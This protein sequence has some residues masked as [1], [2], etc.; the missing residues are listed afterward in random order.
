MLS[1]AIILQNIIL[2][3]Y[4]MSCWTL[5]M[6]NISVQFSS[7][8]S[9][10]HVWLFVTPWTIESGVCSLSLCQGLFPTQ[11]SNSGLMHCRQTLY[12]LSHKG[13]PRILEWVAYPFTGG[14]SLPRNQTG[15]SCIAGG[16]FIDWAIREALEEKWVHVY[17][18]LSPFAVHLKLSQ[19]C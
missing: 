1:T 9:L 3:C 12:Q 5:N 14:A 7:F 17:V 6:R 16:F 4:H 19:L 8:Q 18:W 11:G 13:S 2:E 10:S 15:V